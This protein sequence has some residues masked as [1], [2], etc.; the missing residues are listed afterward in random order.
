MKIENEKDAQAVIEFITLA[1]RLTFKDFTVAEG[2]KFI[3]G[4][5]W[6]VEAIRKF[7]DVQA[8]GPLQQTVTQNVTSIDK[9]K[10]KKK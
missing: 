9:G 2:Y 5:E 1:R 6:M 8:Q 10:A 3:G 4:L 7:K